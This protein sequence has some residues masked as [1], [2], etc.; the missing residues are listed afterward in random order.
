MKKTTALDLE[1]LANPW[2]K[3]RKE[4]RRIQEERPTDK[5]AGTI[6]KEN[7]TN[8]HTLE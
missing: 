4:G 5:Y 8:Q 7:K 2:R 3:G 1:Y 6:V